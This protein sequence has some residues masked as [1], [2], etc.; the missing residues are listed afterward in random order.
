[1][2]T[3][4]Y[5]HEKEC[6]QCGSNLKEVLHIGKSSA[7]W[8]FSLHVIPYE[9]LNTLDDWIKRF[10]TG[11][12]IR[13]EYGHKHSVEELLSRIKDRE[14]KGQEPQRHIIDG[15][16]CVGYGEGTWDYIAGNFS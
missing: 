7:G 15:R 4:F 14:W 1:M 8:C 10:E 5:W 3:N 11:G 12:V 2:G 6:E 9:G 16:H 13:D